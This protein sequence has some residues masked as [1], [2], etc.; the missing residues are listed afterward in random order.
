[1][2]M[3]IFSGNRRNT[4]SYTAA[5]L[6]L[7]MSAAASAQ[8]VTLTFEPGQSLAVSR[9]VRNELHGDSDFLRAVANLTSLGFCAETQCGSVPCKS[10]QEYVLYADPLE[11]KRKHRKSSNLY[12]ES[13]VCDSAPPS[14][15]QSFSSLDL[16]YAPQLQL[17]NHP[18]LL[19]IQN[20]EDS[21]ELTVEPSETE[22]SSS[23]SGIGGSPR[24]AKKTALAQYTHFMIHTSSRIKT[25][26][27]E[28]G[29]LMRSYRLRWKDFIA[30]RIQ[31]IE[32]QSPD[33]FAPREEEKSLALFESQPEAKDY[34]LPSLEKVNAEIAAEAK[35]RAHPQR[36][37]FLN[38]LASYLRKRLRAIEG[39]HHHENPDYTQLAP[40]FQKHYWRN[41][42][43]TQRFLMGLQLHKT[44]K[45]EIKVI[46]AVREQ[47]T[48]LSEG[49]ARHLQQVGQADDPDQKDQ[50]ILALRKLES[51]RVNAALVKY[52]ARHPYQP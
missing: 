46:A 6:P 26:I 14:L 10:V 35:A 5:L 47:I 24:A 52:L 41:L 9:Q 42:Q 11:P 30:F 32:A 18:L 21:S 25:D 33:L 12:F 50:E 15:M 19:P 39:I 1:M 38:K 3:L 45:H 28:A 27:A 8:E 2:N 48:E 31:R 16:K 17:A 49:K 34:A 51:K 36:L 29:A 44:R 22:R 4:L 7:F 20:Y 40:Q 23:C 13:I 37:E 43:A